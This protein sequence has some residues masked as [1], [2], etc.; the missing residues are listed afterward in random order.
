MSNTH[1]CDSLS[2]CL[3]RKMSIAMV[4]TVAWKYIRIYNESASQCFMIL[5]NIMYTRCTFEMQRASR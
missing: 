2:I 4:M 5:G 1:A 3:N